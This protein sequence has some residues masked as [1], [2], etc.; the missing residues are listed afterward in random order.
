[1]TITSETIELPAETIESEQDDNIVSDLFVSI[2]G[3]GPY[4]GKTMAFVR[5]H[6]CNLNCKWCDTITHPRFTLNAAIAW[7]EQQ[8]RKSTGIDCVCFT[9]GEPLLH[10]DAIHTIISHFRSQHIKYHLETNGNLLRRLAIDLNSVEE[11]PLPMA[12][13]FEAIVV[14]PK[15]LSTSLQTELSTISTIENIYTPTG[16][17]YLKFVGYPTSNIMQDMLKWIPDWYGDQ[18]VY[19]SPIN[20]H[21]SLDVDALKRASYLITKLFPRFT[22]TL[23]LHK[24]IGV[25]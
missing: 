8:L 22:L 16:N 14:S 7:L 25:Q 3:E 5:F 18:P 12:A 11:R 19:F 21:G 1:V 13:Y 9:G 4:L 20:S 17:I 2:Q 23:Q 24:L 15:A 6:G 10:T